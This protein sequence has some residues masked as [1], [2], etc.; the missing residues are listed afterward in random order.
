M[1]VLGEIRKRSWILIAVVALGLLAFLIEP[2][3]L[4]NNLN[5]INPN[6]F[7]EV[8]DRVISRED[9]DA[10]MFA[11]RQ[12]SQGR[13]PEMMLRNGA[14]EGAIRNKLIH[15]QAE[16]A[17]LE[18]NEE[19]LYAYNP[20]LKASID[21]LQAAANSGDKNAKNQLQQIPDFLKAQIAGLRTNLYNSLLSTTLL[22]NKLEVQHAQN[23]ASTQA[24]IDYVKVDYDSYNAKHKTEVSDQDL[25]NYINEHK[26]LFKREASTNFHYVFFP[27]TPS[28]QDK[29]L[30][31]KNLDAFKN[32]GLEYDIE[33]GEV[34]DSIQSFV[35]TSN[36][37]VY[38]A[39]Y[40]LEPFNNNYYG[41]QQISQQFTPE[42]ANWVK[43]A[44]IGQVYGPFERSD[45]YVFSKLSD[46]KA[47]DSIR[48]RHILIGFKGGPNPASTRTKEEAQTKAN[49]LLQQVQSN[50]NSFAFVAKENSEDPGSAQKGGELGW[51][52]ENSPL[53]KEYLDF[54]QN[55]SVG[56]TGIVESQFGFH[57]INVEEK[58][59]GTAY[60]LANVVRE[61][62]SSK[63]TEDAL[64][65]KANAFLASVKDKKLQ[66]F[67]NEAS[68][69]NYSQNEVKDVSRFQGII[70]PLNSDKDDDIIS[71][72]F[73][74][75][76]EVGDTNIFTTSN[77]DY[78]VVRITGKAEK[79]IATPKQIREE[80]ETIVRNEKIGKQAPSVLK[81]KSIDALTSEYKGVKATDSISMAQYILPNGGMEPKVVGT[82]FGMKPN[83]VS[84]PIGGNSGLYKVAL[85]SK[86]SG[87]QPAN[88]EQIKQA[89]MQ[90]SRS[91]GGIIIQSL[92]QE[93]EIEDDRAKIFR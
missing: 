65:Q 61:S 78:V 42:V 53:V 68:Q 38:V 10:S 56:T 24:V 91:Q 76:N 60:Q 34:I 32:G 66:D 74:P 37:S 77:G 45:Y 3:S 62:R 80:Y 14:W 83:T 27:N 39:Q 51:V 20:D 13:T 69:K 19:V 81:D 5:Q 22:T 47:L 79:G 73:N 18:V 59:Q 67:V 8:N 28:A 63:E 43:T 26:N 31:E 9:Y 16:K 55:N 15:V 30:F 71:W 41:I 23:N 48:S 7:G 85:K 46:K 12:Q 36:D 17:G 89:L 50:P 57:I 92:R 52:T 90:Q 87:A 33:T 70:Q 84:K 35:S 82:A 88:S 29:Q 44:S 2:G 11:L 40:S 49:E 1:A 75:D 21:E 25:Q 64:Y 58:K 86:T 72:T 93:A 6:N 4:I 54:I